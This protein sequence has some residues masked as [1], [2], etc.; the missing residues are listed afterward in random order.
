MKGALLSIILTMTSAVKNDSTFPKSLSCIYETATFSLRNSYTTQNESEFRTSFSFDN[1]ALNQI[2]NTSMQ[3]EVTLG[4]TDS[5]VQWKE[6]KLKTFPIDI[7]A[8]DQSNFPNGNFTFNQTGNNDHHNNSKD[9]SN[10]PNGNFTF[11]QTGNNDHH[12]NS[13]DQSNFPNGNFIFNQT[14]NN[15]HHNNSKDQSHFLNGNFTFNQTGNNDHHNNSKDQSNFPNGNYTF[16]RTGNTNHQDHS[17]DKTNFS[18]NNHTHL[19]DSGIWNVTQTDICI[20]FLTFIPII[21]LRISVEPVTYV[22]SIFSYIACVIS[23]FG[24]VCN[25][26]L[27]VILLK[28]K[29]KSLSILLPCLLI[30]NILLFVFLIVFSSVSLFGIRVHFFPLFPL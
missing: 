24:L 22:T 16:N 13:K 17:Q 4:Q 29:I 9:Q 7:P 14:V 28:H 12:N 15:D 18:K 3:M 11:N 26:L 19:N 5:Y 25:V 30:F 20:S 6:S 2:K 1:H 27:L 21:E 23:M 8:E 10:F